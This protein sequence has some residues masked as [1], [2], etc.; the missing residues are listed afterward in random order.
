MDILL[1]EK[2]RAET[3]PHESQEEPH[4]LML[5]FCIGT[6]ERDGRRFVLHSFPAFPLKGFALSYA[7]TV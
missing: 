4:N 2:K 6:H 5:R 1:T 7:P 3:H